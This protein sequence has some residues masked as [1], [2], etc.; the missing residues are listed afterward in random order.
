MKLVKNNIDEMP[1]KNIPPMY[2]FGGCNVSVQQD[3][4][5]T[6]EQLYWYGNNNDENIPI[7]MITLKDGTKISA[8]FESWEEAKDVLNIY[9]REFIKGV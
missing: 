6:V 2:C 9:K 3:K 1:I 8:D 7:L 4:I 5:D